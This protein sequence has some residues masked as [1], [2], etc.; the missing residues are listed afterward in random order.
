L[1]SIRLADISEKSRGQ[2]RHMAE[3]EGIESVHLEIQD[4]KAPGFEYNFLRIF[5]TQVLML[6]VNAKVFPGSRFPGT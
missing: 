2:A 5:P 4:V 3:A 1:R 6:Q